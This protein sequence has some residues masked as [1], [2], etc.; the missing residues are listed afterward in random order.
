[1]PF[2][3]VATQASL[4]VREIT[5][6]KRD[7]LPMV[8][9]GTVAQAEYDCPAGTLPSTSESVV[10]LIAEPADVEKHGIH[11]VLPV[12]DSVMP[13]TV[14][15]VLTPGWVHAAAPV[16]GMEIGLDCCTPCVPMGLMVMSDRAVAAVDSAV[17]LTPACSTTMGA[18]AGVADGDG[19]GSATGANP[20]PPY[21]VLGHDFWRP[22]A[23][24][25]VPANVVSYNMM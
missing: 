12:G 10:E 14:V 4:S 5:E 25:D 2:G 24:P 19:L 8:E 3:E 1:M 7:A 15:V 13:P 9:M 16:D 17:S 21:S 18:A 6:E 22:T 23:N 11:T 20:T